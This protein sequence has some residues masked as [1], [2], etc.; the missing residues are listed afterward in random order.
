MM[1]RREREALDRHITGNWGENQFRDWDDDEPAND[2]DDD[3]E[4]EAL[5]EFDD[6]DL[7]TDLA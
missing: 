6:D 1:D 7:D 5:N 3:S 4:P 2:V